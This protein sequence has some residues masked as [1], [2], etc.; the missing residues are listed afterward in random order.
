[1]DSYHES[2]IIPY[3]A[4]DK[5]LTDSRTEVDQRKWNDEWIENREYNDDH[6]DHH[7]IREPI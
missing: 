7:M 2:Q 5:L 4:Y 1:V 3:D 6:H